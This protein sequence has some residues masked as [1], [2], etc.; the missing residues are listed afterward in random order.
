MRPAAVQLLLNLSLLLLASSYVLEIIS[1]S[2]ALL[3]NMADDVYVIITSQKKM[4]EPAFLH[5]THASY[6]SSVE[7][8]V[9]HSNNERGRSYDELLL[10]Y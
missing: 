4:S 7:A 2:Y 1:T 9:V 10:V 5:K 3:L 8:V 6:V